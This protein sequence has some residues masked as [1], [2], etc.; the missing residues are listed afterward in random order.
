MEAGEEIAITRRGIEVARLVPS[1]GDVR[2]DRAETV[3][4]AREKFAQVAAF[5]ER[6]ITAEGRKG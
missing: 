6:A 3:R 4:H 2:A 1:T 5:D